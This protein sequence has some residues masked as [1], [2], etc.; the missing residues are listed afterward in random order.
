MMLSEVIS[1]LMSLYRA[2]GDTEVF[3]PDGTGDIEKVREVYKE[4]WADNRDIIIIS[5]DKY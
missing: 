2:H 5:P 3:I 1:K 4:I